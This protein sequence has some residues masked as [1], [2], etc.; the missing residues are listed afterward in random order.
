MCG[1]DAAD[2]ESIAALTAGLIA[3][4]KACFAAAGL[5]VVPDEEFT[6]NLSVFTSKPVEGQ[7][8]AGGST[9]QSVSW[10]GIG[11]DGLPERRDRAARAVARRADA[12]ECAR[13]QQRMA[14]FIRG[15]RT[16]APWTR[17][18]C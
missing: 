1:P 3:E 7:S 12:A 16:S 8:R 2:S 6:A 10:P 13:V 15:R 14:R 4:A 9:W 5:S 11:G 18:L 17:R